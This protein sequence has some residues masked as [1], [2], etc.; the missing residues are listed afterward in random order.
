M[1]LAVKAF[2]LKYRYV[3]T[4]RRATRPH[5][6]RARL[7]AALAYGAARSPCVAAAVSLCL[8]C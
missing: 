1:K 6:P 8:L 4:A 7:R 2:K 5:A 3:V